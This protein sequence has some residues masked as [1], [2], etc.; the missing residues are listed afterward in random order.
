MLLTGRCRCGAA[1]DAGLLNRRALYGPIGAKYA[2]V[3]GLWT[4]ECVAAEAFV[5]V[6]T[7]VRR[8]EFGS[9]GAAV[10]AGKCGFENW[11]LQHIRAPNGEL[12]WPAAWI[13][14]AT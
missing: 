11:R 1:A 9:C 4:K 3:A 13:Q 10:R 8:H 7:C 14:D 6:D 12:Q 5:K 2:A